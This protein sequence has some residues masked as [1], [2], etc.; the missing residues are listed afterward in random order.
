MDREFLL[1]HLTHKVEVWQVT[2]LDEWN[3]RGTEFYAQVPCL[4]DE[5]SGRRETTSTA[6]DV[7][8]YNF[9]VTLTHSVPIEIGWLLKDAR[10]EEGELIFEEAEVQDIR[11][12]RVPGEGVRGLLVFANKKNST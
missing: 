6:G 1:T 10:D 12:Y 5:A 11:K 2:G 8:T 4:V 3:Q 7:V 9:A